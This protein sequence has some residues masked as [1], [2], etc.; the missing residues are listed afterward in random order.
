MP[1]YY[2]ATADVKN[3]F[4]ALMKEKVS[5]IRQDVRQEVY[6]ELSKQA[7]A[8]KERIVESMNTL[9]NNVISEEMKKIDLHRKNLIKEKLKLQEAQKSLD[10][11]LADKEAVIK[12]SFNKK[13]AQLQESLKASYEAKKDDFV[14]KASQFI[15]ETVKKQVME[16]KDDKKQFAESI[17]KFGKFISEQVKANVKEHKDE[18]KSLDALRVRLV[19]ESA[20]KLSKAK[21]K[22]YNNAADKMEKFVNETMNREITEFRKE[23]ADN[24][25]KSFGSKIFE[26]FAKEFAVKFFN[27]NKVV[28]GLLE[29][30]KANQN[31]LLHSNKVLEE[32]ATKALNENKQLKAVNDKLV[33]AKIIN[34]SIGHLAKDKQDMIKNLVKEVPT[35]KLNESVKKYIPMIL[36]NSTK[37]V[38]NKGESV[39]K[40]SKKPVYLTGNNTNKVAMNVEDMGGLDVDAEISKIIANSKLI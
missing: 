22:F 5:Q 8:D 38:I 15:N 39:L 27:E 18:M 14:T 13:L 40:E 29:S 3:A 30:V 37:S 33:R 20:E 28:N 17:E 16:F 25:K 7:K 19:K 10:K 23:I 34:E 32:K 11:L 1:S 26:A 21:Q 2:N 9:T 36:S 4:N 12:E 6:E 31:K 24:R 35:E